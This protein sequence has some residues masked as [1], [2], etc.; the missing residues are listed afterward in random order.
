MSIEELLKKELFNC[1][2]SQCNEV[3]AR[4]KA[5]KGNEALSRVWSDTPEDYPPI[6]VSLARF[7]VR[8]ETLAFIDET[9]PQAWFR[10]MFVPAVREA[11]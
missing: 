7:A 2:E 6:I 1:G 3:M 8:R 4:V 9:C 5:S 11:S 10:E